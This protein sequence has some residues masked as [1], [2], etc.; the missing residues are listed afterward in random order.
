M[1]IVISSSRH[2][3]ARAI[4]L[5]PPTSYCGDSVTSNLDFYLPQTDP[6]VTFDIGNRHV[7]HTK[8]SRDARTDA[9][10][11]RRG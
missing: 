5:N 6:I 4:N 2:I 8:T 9:G 11:G 10:T 7:G 1:K 3:V